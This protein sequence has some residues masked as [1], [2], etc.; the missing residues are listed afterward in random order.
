MIDEGFINRTYRTSVVAWGVATI[1]CLVL[2]FWFVAI[3]L[4]IGSA[5]S[6]GVLAGFER[7]VR[8]TF[9][10][11][12]VAHK[13]TIAKFW[14]MKTVVIAGVIAGVVLTRRFD[15]II[16]FCVGV[17]LTQVVMFLKVIGIMLLEWMNK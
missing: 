16:G 6:I 7:V 14:L 3:G 12:G 10:P 1:V 11:G 9:V 13:W 4:T 15:L 2:R 8:R 5:L 17:A